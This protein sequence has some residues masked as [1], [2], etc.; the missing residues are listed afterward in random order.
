MKIAT[1]TLHLPFNY[2]N[3]LQMFSLHRYLLEQGYEAEVLSHWYFED[4]NEILYYHNL[5]RN[6]AWRKLLFLLRCLLF[7]GQWTQFLR[8]TN[9][10]RWQDKSIHWSEVT[11]ANSHFPT[12]KLKYDAIV[13]GSDQIWNP[14]HRTSDFFLLGDF[15]ATIR[16]IAYAA[17]FGGSDFPENRREFFQRHLKGFNAI[18]VR[19]SSAVD[20]LHT[21]NLDS[22]LVCDPTLLHTREEWCGLLGIQPD[23]EAKPELMMYFVT[24]SHR[25]LWKEACRVAQ[26]SKK[27]VHVYVFSWSHLT[28]CRWRPLRVGLRRCLTNLYIRS[29]LFFAGVRLHFA[30]D[31]TEF[32]RRIASTEGLITDSFHGMMFATIFGKKC[33]VVIGT[34][35]ERQQMSARLRNFISEYSNPEILTE[36]PDLQAMRPLGISSG[37]LTLIQKSKAWL[38]AALGKE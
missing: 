27:K 25:V 11:G 6:N 26:E 18:S 36:K 2:G 35:P 37:L 30:A 31:P 10:K 7:N 4:Q 29:R 12:D 17:S 19:E 34:H 16:K 22:T 33:N 14:V 1:L 38:T 3:A 9:I 24:P 21:M 8:E 28:D 15:P 20:I 5:L 32:V 13:V 23:L